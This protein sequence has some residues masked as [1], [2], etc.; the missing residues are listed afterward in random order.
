MTR[1]RL[2]NRR[3]SGTFEFDVGSL[4]YACSFSRFSDG[5]VGE[6]FL[7]NTK[8]G[9]QSDANARESAIAASLALQFG[10]PLE[11][12]RGAVLRNA[13]RRGHRCHRERKRRRAMTLGSHQRT[14]GGSQSYITPPSIL[15]ELGPFVTDPCAANPQPW[16]IGMRYNFT[17][18]DDGLSREWCDRTFVN[19]PFDTRGVERWVC[20]LAEHNHGTLLTH[21]RPETDWFALVWKHASGILFLRH[22]VN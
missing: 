4:H 7:Q 10:C 19:P 5:R 1:K 9:S 22:R 21:V 12:L 8:A 17:E 3:S 16:L 11:T 6:L 18:R 15:R 2:P 14:V 13:T 20:K